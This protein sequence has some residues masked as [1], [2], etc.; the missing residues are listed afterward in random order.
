MKAV[1]VGAG[2]GGLAAAIALRRIGWDV[3]VLERAPE[4]EPLGAGITIWPNALRA[5]DTIDVDIEE[6]SVPAGEGAGLR[7][8]AGKVVAGSEGVEL[9][10]LHRGELQN[11]LLAA[12]P[13]G[14]VRT[15]CP[16]S[17]VL[18]DSV[19]TGDEAISADLVVAADGINSTIRGQLWPGVR[20]EYR[21]YTAWRGV[22]ARHTI[23]VTDPAQAG[24]TWGPGVRFGIVPLPEGGVYWYAAANA[25]QDE[26]FPDEHAEVVRRFGSWHQPIPTVLAATVPGAVLHH[27]I[28]DLPALPTYVNGRVALLGDAA[29]AMTPDLGQGG[30]QALEDAVVLAGCLADAGEV[31]D[32]LARYDAERRPR[33]QSIAKLARQIGRFAQADGVL[34]SLRMVAM[35]FIPER[36]TARQIEQVT[37]WTAPQLG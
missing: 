28:Y 15:G 19:L 7:N 2:I 27:D 34:G 9:R 5:L 8:P 4:L 14:T 3:T 31:G 18:D 32:G 13:D 30:C 24:E 23:T 11:A 26:R 1:V 16:V 25:R 36:V 35:R 29:H 21:G 12:L 10:A 37:T 17:K 33:T 20:P 6:V 22:T